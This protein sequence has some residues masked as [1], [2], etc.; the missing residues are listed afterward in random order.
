MKTAGERWITDVGSS[1]KIRCIP[2]AVNLVDLDK[3]G[4]S[5]ALSIKGLKTC[6]Q[7]FGLTTEDTMILLPTGLREVKDPYFLVDEISAWHTESDP[8]IHLVLVGP[9]LDR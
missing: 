8:Q 9:K 3:P 7:L 4:T 1:A 6:R 5:D 2:Q